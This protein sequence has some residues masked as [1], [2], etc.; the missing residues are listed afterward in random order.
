MPIAMTQNNQVFTLF[1]IF[2]LNCLE[3]STAAVLP[4]HQLAGRLSCDSSHISYF[5]GNVVPIISA[6][7]ILGI[8][9]S[10]ISF[11]GRKPL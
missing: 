11:A 3:H 6:G 10:G 4:D 7:K 1:H 2:R 5:A 8:M 9:I